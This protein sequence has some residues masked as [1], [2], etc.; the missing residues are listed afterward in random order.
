MYVL[1]C[2]CLCVCV[3]VCVLA[4][5]CVSVCMCLRVCV[6]VLAC[7]CLCVSVCVGVTLVIQQVKR[8]RRNVLSFVSCPDVPHLLTLSHKSHDLR[9]K[10]TEHKKCVVDFLYNFCLQHFSSSEELSGILSNTYLG[11]RVKYPLFLLDFNETSN[12]SADFQK[13]LKYQIS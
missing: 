4:F 10:V 5:V 12:F 7:V 1:A 13:I 11:L 8:M 3:R 6:C 2:V 9:K